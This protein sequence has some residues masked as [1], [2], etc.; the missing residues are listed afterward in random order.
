[1]RAVWTVIKTTLTTFYV[2]FSFVPALLLVIIGAGRLFG[3]A[4]VVRELI[5]IA[6]DLGGLVGIRAMRILVESLQEQEISTSATV[7][8]VLVLLFSASRVFH[9]LRYALNRA[10]GTALKDKPDLRTRVVHRVGALLTLLGIGLAL[11]LSLVLDAALLALGNII[12]M[13]FLPDRLRVV[14][15]RGLNLI[16]S[17]GIVALTSA[18]LYKTLPDVRPG[19]RATWAG[20]VLN[21]VL[22][23]LGRVLVGIYLGESS[24]SSASGVGGAV[25]SILIWVYYSAQAFV[26][27][28]VVSRT[29]QH[30]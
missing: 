30:H 6:G 27:G 24:L 17:G 28:A 29:I 14:L 22:F 12:T 21:A 19:W 9:Q 11:L 16:V 1:M 13:P 18:A 15:L 2:M 3:V 23:T 5:D 10:W 4:T 7:L 26:L 25:I 8:S 20:A